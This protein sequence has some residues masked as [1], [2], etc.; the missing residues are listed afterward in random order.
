MMNRFI[1]S[2]V[3]MVNIDL[4]DGLSMSVIL[5]FGFGVMGGF[6]SGILRVCSGESTEFS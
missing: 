3:N 1:R 4:C 2:V 5:G 6:I